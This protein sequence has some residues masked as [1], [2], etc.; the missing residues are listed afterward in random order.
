MNARD[1]IA[2][3]ILEEYCLG[4]LNA[5]EQDVVLQMCSL[6]PQVKKELT[7]I[8]HTME[9][10][11]AGKAVNPGAGMRQKILDSLG[12]HEPA[13]VLDL[14]NLPVTDKNSNHLSWLTAL[15]H[16]IPA[17]PSEDFFCH[18]LRDEDKFAQMLVVSKIDVL[19]ETHDNMMESFLILKGE[20]KCRIDNNIFM[21]GPGDFLEV[22]IGQQHDVK[23]LSPYIAAAICVTII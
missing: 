21:L 9:K 20:C 17:E 16:L 8:E 5:D 22:P 13:V 14:D 23:I 11:A 12:F 6:F 2:S 15:E 1:Y 3:G 4:L 18:V 19:P 7:A 10:M